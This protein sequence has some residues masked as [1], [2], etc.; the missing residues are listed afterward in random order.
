VSI[1]EIMDTIE[2][3]CAEEVSETSELE[4]RREGDDLRVDAGSPQA[5]WRAAVQKLTFQL[6]AAPVTS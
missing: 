2:A 5:V 1:S 3:G 6:N 4:R